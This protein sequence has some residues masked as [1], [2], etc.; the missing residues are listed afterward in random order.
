VRF[1]GYVDDNEL[2]DYYRN[3]DIFVAPSLYESFGLIYLEAMAWGK[4]VIGCD[5]GGALE[6]I[7]GGET[8]IIIQPEDE[9]ALAEAIIKLKDEILRSEMGEKGR[10]R[11][12]NDFSNKIMAEN[13]YKIYNNILHDLSAKDSNLIL[14]EN[15]NQP[16]LYSKKL[17]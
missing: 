11:V 3:C 2:K 13:T 7:E 14:D 6:I 9:N 17:S 8:G 4:P 5:A 10:R 12:E 1:V 15:L 16:N